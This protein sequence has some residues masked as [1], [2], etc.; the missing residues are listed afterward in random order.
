MNGAYDL[1]THDL[2]KSELAHDRPSLTAQLILHV[3][4]GQE[5]PFYGV[6]QRKSSPRS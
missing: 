1:F 6:L 4:G 5:R 2:E 3:L